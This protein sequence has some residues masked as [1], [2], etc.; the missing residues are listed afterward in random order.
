MQTSVCVDEI[1]MIISN[2]QHNF[3][4]ST[5]MCDVQTGSTV[6]GFEA[7]VFDAASYQANDALKAALMRGGRSMYYQ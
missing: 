5:R 2:V 3:R 1:S 4:F 7:F 6:L